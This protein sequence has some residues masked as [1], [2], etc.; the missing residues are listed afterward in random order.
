LDNKVL[1]RAN[2]L[3]EASETV[4]IF[5]YGGLGL[6]KKGQSVISSRQ[7]D[8]S[9]LDFQINNVTAYYNTASSL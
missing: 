1:G 3:P 8:G 2:T 6:T 9:T 4:Y 7:F 5:K